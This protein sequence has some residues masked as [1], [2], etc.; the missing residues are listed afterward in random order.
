MLSE[1]D[2]DKG[3]VN[4]V[5]TKVLQR[6]FFTSTYLKLIQ[7]HCTASSLRHPVGDIELDRAKGRKMYSRPEK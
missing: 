4:L 7:G 2:R 1:L 5:Q 6:C 3:R